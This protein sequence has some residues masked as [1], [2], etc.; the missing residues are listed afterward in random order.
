[1]GGNNAGHHP[2]AGGMFEDLRLLGV[3]LL[4]KYQPQ[5]GLARPLPA[6]P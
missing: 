6:M 2:L 5:V 1:M 4:I 3:Q